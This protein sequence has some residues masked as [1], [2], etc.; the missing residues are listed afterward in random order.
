[1]INALIARR[2]T[3]IFVVLFFCFVLLMTTVSN[4]SERETYIKVGLF[5]GET[6]VSTVEL[7]SADGFALMSEQG[8]NLVYLKSLAEYETLIA[9]V[10]A[11]LVVIKAENGAVI[12][13]DF[14]K[15][16]V[17]MSAKDGINDRTV[18]I[19]GKT[20]RDGV[21]LLAESNS[22]LTVINY[23]T[24]ESYIKGVLNAEMSY[25]YPTEAL[26]AQA[27]TARSYALANL[28]KHIKYGFDL[29]ATNCCQVYK[30]V[31]AEYE[32][33]DAAC[34]ATRGLVMS[35]N[36]DVVA[37]YYFA[38]SG[39]YTQNSEDVWTSALG[40]LRAV[41]DNFAPLYSWNGQITFAELKA[42]LEKAGY[43]PGNIRA[44]Y[45]GSRYESG[46]VAELVIEG[47]NEKIVLS[48]ESIRTTLGTSVVKSSRFSMGASENPLIRTGNLEGT[49]SL[50]SSSGVT[51]IRQTMH[52]F[53]G[54]GQLSEIL[55]D[56][57]KI[58]DGSEVTDAT[59]LQSQ[60][61][62]FTEEEVTS[63]QIFFSGL[64]YGH[65]VGMS[66]SSAKEMAN[67]GY[68]YEDILHYF[69]TNITIAPLDGLLN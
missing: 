58:Y 41:K 48:K 18:S 57:V 53:S 40:Y 49:L 56:A 47:T 10:Q 43:S 62:E 9:T 64:G 60:E 46:Y 28:G 55:I 36:G 23:V 14:A 26:K 45:I 25:A 5:Y 19:N 24:V 1:M 15:E 22:N 2:N 4:A 61:M 30:G 63:G 6:S 21:V 17:L 13:N 68:A 7:K 52:I 12:S 35:Y 27:I 3:R 42:K 31:S 51:S 11:G 50:Y 59:N 29:C 38:N 65:G 67:Q 33:T 54:G 34:E 66:Q 16:N 44:V 20:Y 32:E 39:G 8:G 69:Y 37:G